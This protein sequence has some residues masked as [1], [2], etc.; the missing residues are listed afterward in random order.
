MLKRDTNK[1]TFREEWSEEDG[2]YIARCLE[3]PSLSAHGDSPE[4][5]LKELRAVIELVVDDMAK[6]GECIPEPLSVRPYSGKLVLRIPK[7]VHR[8]ISIQAAEEGVSLNQYL[9]SKL[10]Y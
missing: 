8:S 1:Y 6:A 9:V 10:A 3:F 7:A 5:A 2:V 4:S